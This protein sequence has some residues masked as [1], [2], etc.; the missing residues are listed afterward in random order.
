MDMSIISEACYAGE[1]LFCSNLK[2]REIQAE[3]EQYCSD[4]FV[5]IC[6]KIKQNLDDKSFDYAENGI[7]VG[8]GLIEELLY[9]E[10]DQVLRE[11][12]ISPNADA[13]A[14]EVSV[15]FSFLT[16]FLRKHEIVDED[17]LCFELHRRGGPLRVSEWIYSLMRLQDS[18]IRS[19]QM[20]ENYFKLYTGYPVHIK[21][22]K[23][24]LN[25]DAFYTG[26]RKDGSTYVYRIDDDVY[27]NK[28][29]LGGSY[30]AVKQFSDGRTHEVH[31]LIPVNLLNLT[32]ILKENE[33]PSIRMEKDDHALTNSYKDRFMLKKKYFQQQL[34]YLEAKDIRSAVELEIADLRS[35]FGSKYDV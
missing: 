27:G 23:V 34:D 11:Y 26:H 29:I 7:T 13:I 20:V 16:G 33:G 8:K 4:F 15:Q 14:I 17:S 6:K 12:D 10:I 24:D 22:T 2:Q 25:E 35:K 18:S 21:F 9:N 19:G 28:E 5:G 30:E 3:M 1:S 31:H 32:G